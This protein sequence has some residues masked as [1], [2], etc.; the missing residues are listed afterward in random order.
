[1]IVGLF[2]NVLLVFFNLLFYYDLEA[3]KENK[4]KMSNTKKCPGKESLQRINYLFQVGVIQFVLIF[5]FTIKYCECSI[6]AI[7]SANLH[8]LVQK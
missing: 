1:M 5:I 7:F 8:K 3:F 4:I 2:T 6:M